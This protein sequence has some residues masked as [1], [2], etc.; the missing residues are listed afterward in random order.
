MLST[1][2]IST[3][4]DQVA[5]FEAR[6]V[7]VSAL[8]GSLLESTVRSCHPAII[9]AFQNDAGQYT[10][11]GSSIE[12]AANSS[13][14]VTGNCEHTLTQSELVNLIAPKVT[15]YLAHART[16]VAP[17]V[18][19]F[20]RHL[21]EAVSVYRGIIAHDF[22]I[23]TQ[24]LPAPLADS[25]I[26]DSIKKG[27]TVLSRDFEMPLMGL[28]S[29]GSEGL[30]QLLHT[31]APALDAV[32]DSWAEAKG[33]SFISDVWERLF[34]DNV[35]VA[36]TTASNYFLQDQE[37]TDRLLAAFLFSRTMWDNPAEGSQVS[38][39]K[40][41]DTIAELR[42]QVA[43][44]LNQRIANSERGE[45]A[46]NLVLS[47]FNR[48]I[49]VNQN[50]YV[51]WLQSGGSN[52][53]L[54]GNALKSSPS[55]TVTDIDA[56]AENCKAAWARYAAM[57]AMNFNNRMFTKY[58]EAAAMEFSRLMADTTHGDMP[59]NEREIILRRFNAAL[60]ESRI[61]ETRNLFAWG[62]RLLGTSWFYE[63]DAYRILKTISEV[64]E[65]NPDLEPREAAAIAAI[66]YITYWVSGQMMLT[67]V[68]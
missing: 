43:S 6:G 31:G 50:V 2:A 18:E 60:D 1:Q 46:G 30:M 21:D 67:R 62:L 32:I 64:R 26:L 49:V 16:V 45:K 39:S 33:I 38:L 7:I 20:V 65:A 66:D 55:L 36:T 52:E 63:T 22:E 23:V 15:G 27:E 35:S 53:V 29:V 68:G 14:S 25:S 13:D 56:D 41:N 10:L 51:K 8:P 61:E 47:S 34:S 28:P 3:A 57:N 37:G 59:F 42:L 17:A 54:F 12:Y 9:S 40:Y 48:K 4:I 19:E 24:A 5:N 44:R 11:S 58:K